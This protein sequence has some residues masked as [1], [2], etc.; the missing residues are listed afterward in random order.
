M[1]SI[2][3]VEGQL[4]IVNIVIVRLR[5]PGRCEKRTK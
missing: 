5:T 1:V 3:V 2:Q 4:R